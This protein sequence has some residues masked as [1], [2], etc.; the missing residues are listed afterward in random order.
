MRNKIIYLP[1]SM[2]RKV[3]DKEKTI[4][5]RPL[6]D[7]LIV[8]EYDWVPIVFNGTDDNVMVEIDKIRYVLFRDLTDNLARKCG[9]GDVK[10]LKHVL[11]EKYHALDNGSRLYLYEFIV[12]AVSEKVGE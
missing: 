1:Q 8:R 9:Y 4:V 5:V 3:K 2:Y 12:V 6:S 7:R 10:E 11:L